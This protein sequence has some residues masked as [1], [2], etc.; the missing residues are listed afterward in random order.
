MKVKFVP[1]GRSLDDEAAFSAVVAHQDVFR[2]AL[3]RVVAVLDPLLLNELELPV[4]ARVQ[5]DENDAVLV[6]VVHRL[7]LRHVLAVGQAAAHD[8]ATIDQAAIESKGV[9][10]MHPPDV[11]PEEHFAP[12]GSPPALGENCIRVFVVDDGGIGRVG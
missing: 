1:D 3:V 10:R 9:A 12:S 6:R 5:C 4:Q 8:A 7:V 11:R 2:V